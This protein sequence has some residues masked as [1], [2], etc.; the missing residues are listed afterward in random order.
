MQKFDLIVIGGGTGLDI[1]N[2]AVQQNLKVA[3]VEKDMLGGTCLNRGCIP[4][5][6]LIH[7]ADIVQ[8]IKKAET[9][10]INIKGFSIDFQKIMK[11]VNKITDDDSNK[12]KNGLF[13]SENPILYTEECYF[14][15]K[16]EIAFK[17][18][19]KEDKE[20]EKN[21]DDVSNK[22]SKYYTNE[23]ITADK[24]LIVTGTVPKI[25]E[26]KGLAESGFITSDKALRLKKQPKSITF[27]GGGY[28]AC[29]LAHFFGSL[30][31]KINIIQ[32]NSLLIPNEDE[33]ICEK[34]TQIIGKKYQIYLGYDTESVSKVSLNDGSKIFKV[35]ARNKD[36]RNTIEVDSDQLIVST[37]RE[38]NSGI[39]N[40]E[41]T[42]VQL[43]KNGFIK[44][45]KYLETTMPG[46]FAIGDVVGRY[47]FKHNANL[48]AQY[49]YTNL[50]LQITVKMKKR[51]RLIIL[52]CH[53]PYLALLKL[54]A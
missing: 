54:Q 44:V 29:E 45:D 23:T 46:I 20:K 39:L 36:D 32:R 22:N 49:V 11:R 37:G 38:A 8:T 5:K 17:T 26:I 15:G 28:I 14:V 19:E 35:V 31:S 18:R 41:K 34:F 33:Q 30:G 40:L 48:E 53:M 4:S 16:K 42:G 52:P 25:P 27:I 3:L 2:A 6:L 13:Q 24:I 51:L 10:G 7:S 12:I 50:F 21:K 47:Q 43:N 1:A 9:F